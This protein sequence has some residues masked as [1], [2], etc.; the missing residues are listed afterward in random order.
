LGA[1]PDQGNSQGGRFVLFAGLSLRVL[2]HLDSLAIS[3]DHGGVSSD[4]GDKVE[5]VTVSVRAI[6]GKSLIPGVEMRGRRVQTLDSKL[7]EAE[8]RGPRRREFL[9]QETL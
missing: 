8:I 2:D 5:E 7:A 9:K 6:S 4:L 3:L 1:N